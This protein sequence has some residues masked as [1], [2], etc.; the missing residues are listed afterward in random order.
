MSLWSHHNVSINDQVIMPELPS[1][2]FGV[3]MVQA[4]GRDQY[5]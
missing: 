3:G 1:T 2:E 4:V 5:G